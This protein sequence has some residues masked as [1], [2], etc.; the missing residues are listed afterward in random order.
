MRR[1]AAALLLF[2]TSVPLGAWEAKVLTGSCSIAGRTLVDAPVSEAQNT[3]MYFALSGVSAQDLY[4]SMRAQ[5]KP[6]VCRGGGAL[7]KSIGEMRCTR[8]ADGRAFQ[9]WFAIDIA[10]QRITGGVVC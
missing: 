5:A 7:A 3:H 9:C 1:V 4:N 2:T 8:S 10:S 6:D